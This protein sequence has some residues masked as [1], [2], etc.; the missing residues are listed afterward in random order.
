MQGDREF[1]ERI[2]LNRRR[3]ILEY[4]Q[5][6]G[7]KWMNKREHMAFEA[8]GIL[9][10]EMGLGKT[11]MALTTIYANRSSLPSLVIAPVA[12][13]EQ[14]AL[15]SLKFIG[16]EALIV[17]VSSLRRTFEYEE[18]VDGEKIISTRPNPAY[19]SLE[20]IASHDLVIAPHSCFNASSI[21]Y[22]DH[23]LLQADF[24]RVIVDEAHVI[25]NTEAIITTNIARVK[26]PIRWCM[27][28]TPVVT[29]QED[30]SA[31][32]SFVTSGN[33]AVVQE[34][35]ADPMRRAGTY[36][37]RTKEDIGARVA[38]LQCVRLNLKLQMIDF[39]TIERT[40]YAASYRYLQWLL[41]NSEP[42]EKRKWLL[43]GITQLRRLASSCSGKTLALVESFRL[44][45]P[46]TR[47]LIFCNYL[48]EIES[49]TA[50]LRASRVVDVIM[51]YV[52]KMSSKNRNRAVNSFMERRTTMSKALIIQI[53]AG[54]VGLNLQA[55][56][57]VYIMSPHWNA[58]TEQQAIARAHRTGT[59]HVVEVTRFVVKDTVEEYMHNLQQEKLS[60]AA[61]TLV[62]DRLT[63]ALNADE[64][65]GGTVTWM[66]KIFDSHIFDEVPPNDAN[67][68]SDMSDA[69]V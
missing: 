62:D 48:D 64:T 36:M 3:C 53:Q 27:T 23:A 18:I 8:G 45:R 66:G 20:E 28:G 15:E 19:I 13:V 1:L 43:K 12:V 60:I 38:R 69:D 32:L 35:M 68:D 24:G 6:D 44:H 10:D 37:R 14:W 61:T 22:S 25:K 65:I 59:T 34:I 40:T 57:R 5:L 52:G 4:Y 33:G 42:R 55:A 26:A 21:D 30:L 51:P 16:I 63:A 39:S 54:S 46:G 31:L 58:T 49:V 41:A 47:S 29:K 17:S 11:V 2:R 7:V 9:A 56:S 50:A 67:S